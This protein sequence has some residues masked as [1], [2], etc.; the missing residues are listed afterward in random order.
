MEKSKDSDGTNISTCVDLSCC[1]ERE[2]LL[3]KPSMG[4]EWG[5]PQTPDR[6][7]RYS[8]VSHGKMEMITGQHKNDIFL[9]ITI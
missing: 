8:L 3:L 4:H 1:G 6:P 9:L 7:F 5:E 2:N